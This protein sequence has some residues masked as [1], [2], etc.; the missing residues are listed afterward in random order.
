LLS[1]LD[2]FSG[3]NQNCMHSKDESKTTFTH[4]KFLCFLLSERG[5]EANTEKCDEIIRMRSPTNV[6]EVQ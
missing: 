3:Y 1:F 5:I 6:K 2:A 4:R